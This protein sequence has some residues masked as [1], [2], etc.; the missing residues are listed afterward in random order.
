MQTC[1]RHPEA[2][3]FMAT[4][5][6][7]ARDLHDIDARNRAEAA[8]C[9]AL[10]SIGTLDAEIL[11]AHATATTLIVATRQSSSLAYEFAVDV[12]RLPTEAESDPELGEDFRLT[13]NQWHLDWQAADHSADALPSLVAEAHRHLVATGRIRNDTATVHIPEPSMQ[14][15]QN[16]PV[17]LLDLPGA[18]ELPDSQ[19][20][21]HRAAAAASDAFWGHAEN[22]EA[23]FDAGNSVRGIRHCRTGAPLAGRAQVTATV[24]RDFADLDYWYRRGGRERYNAGDWI[25]A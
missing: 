12:F 19:A 6:G 5:P 18:P 8:A 16:R 2:G 21:A 20:D 14:A 3:R 17:R 9:T 22:C 10:A 11:I 15:L 1:R 7:C 25:A 23:C 13:A 4:C 24:A